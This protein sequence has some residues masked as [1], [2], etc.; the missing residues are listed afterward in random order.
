MPPGGIG[1]MGVVAE[2][3]ELLSQPRKTK[4]EEDD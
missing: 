1:G 2:A 4:Q 3:L